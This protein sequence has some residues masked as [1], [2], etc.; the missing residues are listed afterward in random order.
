MCTKVVS[1]SN[2]SWKNSRL[3]AGCNCKYSVYPVHT[4][5]KSVTLEQSLCRAELNAPPVRERAC[6]Q[7][8]AGEVGTFLTSKIA[9]AS[10]SAP[11]LMI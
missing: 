5:S 1:F 11:H 8:G 4:A 7:S 9:Q 2:T 6:A 10:T 3:D